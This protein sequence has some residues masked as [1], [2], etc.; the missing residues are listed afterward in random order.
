MENGS[1]DEYSALSIL[2]A[3]G[4]YPDNP[5]VAI[6]IVRGNI[7]QLLWDLREAAGVSQEVLAVS[8][9]VDYQDIQ[10]LEDAEI[11]K[12]DTIEV[13]GKVLWG[14]GKDLAPLVTQNH[15]G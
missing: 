1:S 11:P 4:Y 3:A 2:K 14:L 12:H 5:G 10:A 7:A 8:A 15:R 6:E 9:G 13:L